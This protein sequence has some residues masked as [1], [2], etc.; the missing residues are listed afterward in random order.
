[1]QETE[2]DVEPEKHE[3]IEWMIEWM[4]EVGVDLI[5]SCN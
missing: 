1:M 3:A 5:Q 4:D 2:K